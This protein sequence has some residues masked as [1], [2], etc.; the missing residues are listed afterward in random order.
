MNGT[1]VLRRL[2]W[3]AAIAVMGVAL[4]GCGKRLAESDF[5]YAAPLLDD[6]LA[7]IAERDYGKFSGSFS[8]AMRA[9]LGE[10]AFPAMIAQLEGTLGEYRGRTFLRAVRARAATGG[11]VD[12]VT[13]RAEY[14]RD[15]SAT[16]TVYISNR[17]G[18]KTVEGFAVT[19]SGG[20]K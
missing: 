3:A 10:G 6:M 17:D 8:P 2:T 4:H 9:A 1:R 15:R 19:P 14:S 18:K 16:M 12:V 20:A 11:E 7:G 13:Y 5:P